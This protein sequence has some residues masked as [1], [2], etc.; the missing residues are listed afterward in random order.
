M[1]TQY[2]LGDAVITTQDNF[3]KEY[4]GQIT[5]IKSMTHQWN[6]SDKKLTY[7]R[8]EATVNGFKRNFLTCDTANLTKVSQWTTKKKKSETLT[9]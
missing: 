2:K 7:Y 6:N 9:R 5:E 3:G 4:Q 1:K 8:I